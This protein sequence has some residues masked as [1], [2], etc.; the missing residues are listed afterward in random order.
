MAAVEA[1]T[2]TVLGVL[3]ACLAVEDEAGEDRSTLHIS[4]TA[5]AARVTKALALVV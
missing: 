1:T 4:D 2:L 5:A 3:M